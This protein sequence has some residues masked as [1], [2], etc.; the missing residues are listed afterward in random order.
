MPPVYLTPLGNFVQGCAV[1]LPNPDPTEIIKSINPGLGRQI[2]QYHIKWFFLV[3]SLSF[4]YTSD[5]Y[6][7]ALY[8]CTQTMPTL[9][10]KAGPKIWTIFR[11]KWLKKSLPFWADTAIFAYNPSKQTPK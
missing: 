1:G 9:V 4:F 2:T 7:Y 3:N 11:Q 6:V 5:K 8:S 10:Q